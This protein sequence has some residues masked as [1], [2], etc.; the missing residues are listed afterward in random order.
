[1]S[2][3]DTDLP[4]FIKRRMFAF[5]RYVKE[6]LFPDGVNTTKFLPK[7]EYRIKITQ[8]ESIIS[9]CSFACFVFSLKELFQEGTIAARDAVTTFES[10]NISAF[11]IGNKIF[12]RENENVL[13]GEHLYSQ[14]LDSISDQNLKQIIEKAKNYHEIIGKYREF[15]F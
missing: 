5:R 1:M 11:S 6:N 3:L 15:S 2:E 10:L 9:E 13:A 8:M 12:E 14:M 7:E 4:L